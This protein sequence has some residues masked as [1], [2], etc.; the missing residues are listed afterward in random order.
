[1][2][3]M[4]CTSPVEKNTESTHNRTEAFA[5]MPLGFGLA[6]C[7]NGKQQ[8]TE[9]TEMRERRAYR[10][11]MNTLKHTI[12]KCQDGRSAGAG[13]EMDTR[14]STLCT[15]DNVLRLAIK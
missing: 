10:T 14:N 11:G 8:M 12:R 4:I 7:M 13:H 3:F 15:K 9:M 5:H 2:S 1:M 6:A